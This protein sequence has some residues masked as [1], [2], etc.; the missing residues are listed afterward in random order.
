ME[1]RVT[2]IEPIFEVQPCVYSEAVNKNFQEK[3]KCSA[4]KVTTFCKWLVEAVIFLVK[5]VSFHF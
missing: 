3:I 1:T 5:K 4:T 2:I